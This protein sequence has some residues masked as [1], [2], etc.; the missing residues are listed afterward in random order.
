MPMS[1]ANGIEL[2]PRWRFGGKN[3]RISRR[4]SSDLNDRDFL[5]SRGFIISPVP[6]NGIFSTMDSKFFSDPICDLA[7]W[8]SDTAFN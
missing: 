6:G 4:T 5:C 7:D 2:F 8:K 1:L 3:E